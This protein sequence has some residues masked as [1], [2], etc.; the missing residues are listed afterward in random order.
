[1]SIDDKVKEVSYERIPGRDF[2]L[3]KFKYELVDWLNKYCYAHNK[4]LKNFHK[5]GKKQLYA[6]YFNIRKKEV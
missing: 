2:Y 3:P 6:I 5:M 4:P 1:M